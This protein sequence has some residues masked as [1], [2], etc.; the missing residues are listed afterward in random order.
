MRVDR[1][2]EESAALTRRDRIRL[3]RAKDAIDANVSGPWSVQAIAREA[4]VSASGLQR[5]FR[6][7]ESKSAFG[8]V[9]LVRLERALQAL[10]TGEANVQEASVIAGYR[11]PANFAT[12]FRRK[13][14]FTPR[15]ALASR[16]A[17][18]R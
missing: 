16:H 18:R 7:S 3:Q 17:G 1:N 2:P 8:Y 10:R 13:Y 15:E 6:L 11:S 12:A 14:G 5:L 9:R 4:G